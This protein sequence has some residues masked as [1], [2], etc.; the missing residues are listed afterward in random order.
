[1]N[2]ELMFT[3]A[4]NAGESIRGFLLRLAE[5]NLYENSRWLEGVPGI[6][7]MIR[8]RLGTC[9]HGVVPPWLKR[10]LDIP[11]EEF[12]MGR[13]YTLFSQTRFC[14]QCLSESPHW[15]FEWEHVFYT[16]CHL[17]GMHM[18]ER[19]SE[20]GEPT[21]WRRP[22][23][24]TCK[25]GASFL[26]MPTEIAKRSE[27][28]LCQLLANSLAAEAN[29]A[30]RCRS[31]K[32]QSTLPISTIRSISLSILIYTL[33]T[34]A[35]S[36]DSHRKV[37]SFNWK[38][39]SDAST[40]V[41]G[42]AELLVNWPENFNSFLYKC[43]DL[44]NPAAPPYSPP[45]R[46]SRLAR[47]IIEI[48]KSDEYE[49][50][51]AEYA[52]FMRQNWFGAINHRHRWATESD[53]ENQPLI[54][55]AK[56]AK[57]LR[58]SLARAKDLVLHGVLIGHVKPG[59]AKRDFTL[60]E[61]S[62]LEIAHNYLNNQMTKKAVSAFLGLTDLRVDELTADGMLR[63]YS[64][65]SSSRAMSSYFSRAEINAF[66]AL[67][68]D[69]NLTHE[70]ED[71]ISCDH[72][73]RHHE[74]S[75]GTF[76]KFIRAIL[77]DLI[78]AECIDPGKTGLKALFLKKTEF[79]RWR[80]TLHHNDP[81]YLTVVEASVSLGLKQEVA[82]HLVRLGIISST[83]SIEGN[84]IHRIISRQSLEEFSSKYVSCAQLAQYLGISPKSAVEKLR[85]AGLAP[86]SGPTVDGCRQYFFRSLDWRLFH[87]RIL[88]TLHK[89]E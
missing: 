64:H 54:P 27:M 44:D 25:C 4:P 28:E 61:L 60:I 89:K 49:F 78:H 75:H 52:K 23:L 68:V 50:L 84:R 62:S 74:F 85:L 59:G 10:S 39:M 3:V 66:W 19:C 45:D 42:A 88:A 31:T 69:K 70:V 67:L 22:N 86:I 32:Y 26:G 83:M 73:L 77:S 36:L 37:K 34:H 72:I 17:H 80:Y 65:L 79:Y 29:A 76:P 58:I 18:L 53:L 57:S 2:H 43:G 12:P 51:I 8:P 14:P 15:R 21:T 56:A 6:S 40:I 13:Y 24:L 16:T 81:N 87:D 38:K 47:A 55:I 48:C 20:C 82:Y 35:N 9:L 33:G 41:L 63:K 71:G 30:V 7:D 11:V 5:A 46:F 1:M